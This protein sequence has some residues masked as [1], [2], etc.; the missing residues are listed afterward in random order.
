MEE[1]YNI[2]E[3]ASRLGCLWF[4]QWKLSGKNGPEPPPKLE[5]LIQKVKARDGHVK[6]EYT[7][8][9]YQDKPVRV[10]REQVKSEGG[11][12]SDRVKSDYVYHLIMIN[13]TIIV[14]NYVVNN[15]R[16]TRRASEDPPVKE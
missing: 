10:K 15:F 5:K 7:K 1:K 11:I 2:Q 9:A 13:S 12:Q 8:Q 6:Y 16:V 4:L 3:Q 14:F